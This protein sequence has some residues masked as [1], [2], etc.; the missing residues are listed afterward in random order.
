VSRIELE[1]R[2]VVDGQYSPMTQHVPLPTTE[3]LEWHHELEVRRLSLEL[4]IAREVHN[5]WV[6]RVDRETKGLRAEIEGLRKRARHRHWWQ[7]ED[8]GDPARA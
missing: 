1:I 4:Q 3:L 8:I 2:T 6:L 5:D 7:Y